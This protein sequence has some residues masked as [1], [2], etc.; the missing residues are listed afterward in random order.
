[1]PKNPIIMKKQGR[2]DKIMKKDYCSDPV[3]RN[4]SGISFKNLMC[5]LLIIKKEYFLSSY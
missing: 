2:Y 5:K 1:M 4:Q 3:E